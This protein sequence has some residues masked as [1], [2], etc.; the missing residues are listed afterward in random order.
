MPYPVRQSVNLQDYWCVYWRRGMPHPALGNPEAF[1]CWATLTAATDA[2]NQE[3]WD[4]LFCAHNEAKQ[5][6]RYGCTMSF[7]LT[8]FPSFNLK[9]ESQPWPMDVFMPTLHKGNKSA[10]DLAAPSRC[11]NQ[12]A[13]KGKIWFLKMWVLN[14]RDCRWGFAVPMAFSYIWYTTHVVHYPRQVNIN[15]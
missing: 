1:N 13:F 3:S 11:W 15:I 5:K 6:D 7:W 8:C 10:K 12:K 4:V 9:V 2:T 14:V